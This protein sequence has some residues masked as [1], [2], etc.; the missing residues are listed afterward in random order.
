MDEA[1]IIY[2]EVSQSTKNSSGFIPVIWSSQTSQMQS[3]RKNDGCQQQ[4]ETDI[5]RFD[6][7]GTEF[8]GWSEGSWARILV[9]TRWRKQAW[10]PELDPQDWRPE[11][12]WLHRAL[13]WLPLTHVSM[14]Y[15]SP[16]QTD[17]LRDKL[18]FQIP[19]RPSP[20]GFTC[21]KS[22]AH[23]NVSHY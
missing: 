1:Y 4:E 5:R 12:T 8:P 13:S 23:I 2:S 21:P 17:S 3:Y 6:L 22:S 15:P 9:L 20:D 7:K 16:S 14:C 11:E 18:S 19:N 10:R